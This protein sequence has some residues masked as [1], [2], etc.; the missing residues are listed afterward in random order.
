MNKKLY[1]PFQQF[2]YITVFSASNPVDN[3]ENIIEKGLTK[4]TRAG[5]KN[6]SYKRGRNKPE[7]IYYKDSSF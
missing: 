4:I 2:N 1:L 3:K 6:Y 7:Y 5:G